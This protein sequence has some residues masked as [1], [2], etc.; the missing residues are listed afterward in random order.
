ML[1]NLT[2]LAVTYGYLG[3]FLVMLANSDFLPLFTET[4]LPLAGYLASQGKLSIFLIIFAAVLGDFIGAI[5]AYYVGY[6]LKEKVVISLINKYGKYI[7]LK[8]S[9]LNRVLKHLRNHGSIIVFIAK[10]TPG[11]KTYTSVAAGMSKIRLIKY[12]IASVCASIIYNSVLTYFG[13][14]LGSNWMV[15]SH[16][17]NRIQITVFLSL[18]LAVMFLINKRLKFVKFPNI[19]RF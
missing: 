19:R 1:V 10:L 6:F 2:S 7:L 12:L 5:I 8:E 16:Y 3:V 9:D 4:T 15:I 18:V 14:Y 11:I 17:L 13:F